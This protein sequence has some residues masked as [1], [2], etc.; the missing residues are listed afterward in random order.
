ML[1]ILVGSSGVGKTSIIDKLSCQHAWKL[2][3]TLTTRDIRLTDVNKEHVDEKEF[4]RLEQEGF[5]FAT[6]NVHKTY[7]GQPQ[8]II[9]KVI[10]HQKEN[11]IFDLSL[12]AVEPYESLNPKLYLI[13]PINTQQLKNQLSARPDRI[14]AA[15]Q[16]YQ[17]LDSMKDRL[18]NKG[19]QIIYNQP[20]NIDQ[21]V[22]TILKNAKSS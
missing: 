1:H 7:Y 18:T 14:E 21:V 9:D 3:E 11:W 5:F 12:E 15:I 10:D 16:D 2:V 22:S 4:K 6:Q 17:N 20:N 13:L 19:Y 8:E